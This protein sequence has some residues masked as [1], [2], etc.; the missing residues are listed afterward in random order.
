MGRAVASTHRAGAVPCAPRTRPR[1]WPGGSTK[2]RQLEA[3]AARVRASSAGIDDVRLGHAE[4]DRRRRPR[5]TV[6][7]AGQAGER[8][9]AHARRGRPRRTRPRAR[10]R[11]RRPARAACRARSRGPGPRSPPGRRASR[12]RPCSAS[13]G[14]WCRPARGSRSSSAQS[15]R[16]DCGSRPVVGSS[17]NSRSG[18]LTSAHATARRCFWPPESLPTQLRRFASSSTIS[19]TSVD[20]RALPVERSE[21]PDDLLDGELLVELRLLQL[22]AEPLPQRPVVGRPSAG[23]APRPRP[24]PARAAPR[25]SRPSSS[26]RRRSGRAGRSTRRRAPRGRG[27]RRRRRRRSACGAPGTRRPAPDRRS[28]TARFL[29]IPASASAASARLNRRCPGRS[30]ILIAAPELDPRLARAPVGRRRRSSDLRRL[31]AAARP[32]RR[33]SRDRPPVARPRAAVRRQPARRRA[34]RPHQGRPGAG[35]HPRS[36]SSP[37][38]RATSASRRGGRRRRRPGRARPGRRAGWTPAPAGRRV[39]R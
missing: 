10:R 31:G 3:A 17:R 4:T 34:H 29:D 1:A 13:S 39:S 22:D 38:T 23:R 36:A 21:E 7:H 18:S 26:C 8:V 19:S 35:R 11:A 24:R 16:R 6:R 28:V 9:G 33:S 2:L 5:R 25:G 20:R 37:T 30:S 32:A 12:P 27:R 14:G 15:W